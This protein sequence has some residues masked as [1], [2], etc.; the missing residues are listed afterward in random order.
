MHILAWFRA[1]WA[2]R[3]NRSKR[4]ISARASEKN[5]KQKSFQLLGGFAPRLPDQGAEDPAGGRLVATFMHEEA[6]ASSFL[7]V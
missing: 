5:V 7:V 2:M 1:F 6:V 3:Q 4:F